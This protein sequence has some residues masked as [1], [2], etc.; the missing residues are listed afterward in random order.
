M[1]IVYIYSIVSIDGYSIHILKIRKEQLDFL[2]HIMNKESLENSTL[3]G[4]TESQG[5]T[6]T[7]LSNNL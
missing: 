2:G 5:E 6:S 3:P 1:D 4:H 7:N